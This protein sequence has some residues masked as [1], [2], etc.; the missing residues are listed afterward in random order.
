MILLLFT[1]QEQTL[2]LTPDQLALRRTGMTATDVAAITGTHPFRTPLDVYLEKTGRREPQPESVRSRWGTLLEPVIRDDYAERHRVRVDV[3]GTLVH[4][5]DKWKIATPD[6]IVYPYA[7]ANAS[8]GLEIKVHSTDVLRTPAMHYGDAG[9]DEVPYHELIQ[10]VWGSEVAC[11]PFW[12]LV[13]FIDGAPTEYTIAHDDELI[14]LLSERA[15]RF[16]I[17]HVRADVPPPPDG[18]NTYGEWL[19]ER[20]KKNNE[21][22][23]DA[24]ALDPSVLADIE[25]L[26]EA[27]GQ[28]KPLEK[29]IDVLE[30]RLK[31]AIGES[32]GLT[33]K[34]RGKPGKI[35]WRHNRDSIVTDWDAVR[36]DMRDAAALVVSAKAPELDLI[37]RFLSKHGGYVAESTT[38]GVQ[39]AAVV[40]ELRATL[41][42][43]AKA[44]T[45]HERTKTVPGNRPLLK[46]RSWSQAQEQ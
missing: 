7:G 21:N 25:A 14:G 40:R 43:I 31:V 44:S 16:L 8:R 46:P 28:Y 39:L 17:D 24:H 32:S 4:P 18:S 6:G 30:Q 27:I 19:K 2:T 9:T 15:E 33:F 11:L 45:E 3:P 38:S 13:V 41:T 5:V 12:D 29:T 37:E 10:S 42:N 20:W 26:R 1:A 36:Q 22:M 35:T 23:L 34:Q